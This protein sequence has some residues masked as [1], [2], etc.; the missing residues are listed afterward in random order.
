MVER[1]R[2]R[3]D[4]PS[5]MAECDANYLRLSRLF[6]AM[7]DEEERSFILALGGRDSQVRI[8]VV[9]R[10]PYTTLL[11]IK[12]LPDV[13]WL[14]Q[15]H[16]RVR[17]YHDARSAEVVECQGV[18]HFRAAYGYPN[19]SMHQPDEKAQVNRL[20]SEFLTLC[21]AQ[22]AARFAPLPTV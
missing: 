21:L 5:Q 6:P 11:D 8:S 16:L 13:S 4:L 17:L 18:R 9:E 2:Y 15:A 22:G 20:L 1:R 12:Q 3:V 10:G 14:A 19:P 7:C